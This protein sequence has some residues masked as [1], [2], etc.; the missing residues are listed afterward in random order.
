MLALRVTAQRSQEDAEEV[1]R[2][3]RRRA[4]E[5]QTEPGPPPNNST[6]WVHQPAPPTSCLITSILLLSGHVVIWH[7]A[8]LQDPCHTLYVL[9][10]N[11]P[12]L[13]LGLRDSSPSECWWIYF[14]FRSQTESTVSI[15]CSADWEGNMSPTGCRWR[16]WEGWRAISCW[17][18][19]QRSDVRAGVI[20]GTF[21]TWDCWEDSTTDLSHSWSTGNK[22]H[23]LLVI[24]NT[25]INTIFYSLNRIIN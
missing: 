19:G 20:R 18:A 6:E 4:R 24:I 12:Q 13:S 11:H 10:Y 5:N 9:I 3:R 23:L 17:S 1:E 16:S 2:E 7:C 22:N 15:T 8:Y 21:I 25:Y 14:V